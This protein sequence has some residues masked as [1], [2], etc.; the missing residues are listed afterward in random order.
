MSWKIVPE[1]YTLCSFGSVTESND[2]EDP[3]EDA[4]A[5]HITVPKGSLM[6]RF[7]NRHW[8]LYPPGYPSGADE[9]SSSGSV[10]NANA[11]WVISQ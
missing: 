3:G 4:P 5:R 2:N 9:D 1:R 10:K 6:F 8:K 11:L 7:G